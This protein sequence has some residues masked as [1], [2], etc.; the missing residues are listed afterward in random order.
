METLL[1]VMRE[2]DD[3]RV[4]IV[5]ATG[6]LDRAWGKPK[7]MVEEPVE[8]PRPDLSCLSPKDL[9]E[10]RRTLAKAAKAGAFPTLNHDREGG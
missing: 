4:K 5:A 7:E 1:Q 10:L 6:V 9:S 3:D 8:R 2:S